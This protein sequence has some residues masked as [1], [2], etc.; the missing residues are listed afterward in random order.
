MHETIQARFQAAAPAV[1][2]CSLRL[3]STRTEQL[4][5]RQDILQPVNT[6][7]DVGAMLTVMDG[8]GLGYAAT[9]DLSESG[10]REAAQRALTWAQRTQDQCVV[11][12]RKV[13]MPR[14]QLEYSSPV[15]IPWDSV[16]LT[17]KIDLLR[18]ICGQL[19]TNDAIVDWE[20]SLWFTEEES[21]YLTTDG[22]RALQHMSYLVP[23]LGV[24]A[25]KGTESQ[26]R[27]FAA[28]GYC[29]QGGLEV[30]DTGDFRT[31]GPQIAEEAVQLLTAP[32]CPEGDMDLVL[33]PDQMLL[34]IHESI[35]H[36]LELDR[37]LGDERNYA[38]TSF[39][40][41]DMFGS[42]RYGSDLLNI[43]YD[44]TRKDEFASYGCDDDGLPATR[45][46]IIRNGILERPLGGVVSQ[47]RAG[48]EGVANSRAASWN[49]PPIDRMANLNLESGESTLDE[50]IGQV[51]QGVY[52]K[53]NCSW[54]IDD[55]RNKFQFGCEWAQLIEN[56]ELTTVV[57]KPNYRGVSATFW[58]SLKG[59]GNEDTVDVLGSP[60][61]GKGEP[62]QC[63]RVGH[64]SPPCLFDKVSVFGGA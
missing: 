48:I 42:Y 12:Y 55:S 41:L 24:V 44:P 26:Q 25:N 56:G 53:T 62:N 13:A 35:G 17:Q 8:G 11:D 32:N 51:E 34:Q 20:A 60:Y 63:V 54:S 10:L 15:E 46:H 1:D 50:L 57:K 9:S 19:K 16:P 30:L 21:L 4:W 28:R 61:C 2:F 29:R 43:T 45:E 7:T 14:P 23:D 6:S 39:V 27:T 64:A 58:R 3:V 40:T 31:A 18:E 59:V 38:G 33:A 36:P 49:R 47:K 5:V 52:M 37:I 22:A